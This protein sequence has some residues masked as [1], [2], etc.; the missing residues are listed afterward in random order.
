MAK[1]KKEEKYLYRW[2]WVAYL[3]WGPIAG[4]AVG[5]ALMMWLTPDGLF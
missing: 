2:E 4:V 1:N 5:I 3:P